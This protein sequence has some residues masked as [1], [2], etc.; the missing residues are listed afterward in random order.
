MG[1]S[2]MREMMLGCRCIYGILRVKDGDSDIVVGSPQNI[3]KAETCF[4]VIGHALREDIELFHF[5]LLKASPV[6]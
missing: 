6:Q 4:H 3:D 1:P 5:K 2:G